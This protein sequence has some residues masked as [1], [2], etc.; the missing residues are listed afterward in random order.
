MRTRLQQSGLQRPGPGSISWEI[1]REMIAV[2]G[3][4]RAI[5]MQLAHPLIAAGVYDHSSFRANP[6]TAVARLRL[7]SPPVVRHLGVTDIPVCGTNDEVLAAH[8]YLADH[9]GPQRLPPDAGT[10]VSVAGPG[11]VPHRSS[12]RSPRTRVP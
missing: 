1:N 6:R 7:A 2:A 12:H 11:R 10:R 3:W 9:L 4:G 5:L 8:G